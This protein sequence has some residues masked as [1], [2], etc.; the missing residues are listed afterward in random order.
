MG[1]TLKRHS[2]ETFAFGLVRLRIFTHTDPVTYRDLSQKTRF[3]RLG[4]CFND[5]MCN[6]DD[7]SNDPA[8]EPKWRMWR[9]NKRRG[10]YGLLLMQATFPVIFFIVLPGTDF[11]QQDRV[12]CTLLGLLALGL[13][14]F[15]SGFGIDEKTNTCK[16]MFS[17]MW[18]PLTLCIVI[19][20]TAIA[21]SSAPSLVS[22][23]I[24]FIAQF[25]ATWV[26]DKASEQLHKA[27]QQ[28]LSPDST[29]E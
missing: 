9:T 2:R 24:L 6:E 10:D 16:L 11:P 4:I 8:T 3:Q 29:T 28:A 21:S 23:F 27:A 15:I 25:I 17:V 1:Y 18:Q 5:V 7:S 19:P 22:V 20:I 13:G 26:C 12:W 14:L